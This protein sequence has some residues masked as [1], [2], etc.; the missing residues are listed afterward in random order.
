MV[1]TL[2]NDRGKLLEDWSITYRLYLSIKKT[3]SLLITGKRQGS[4]LSTEDL[5]L[6]IKTGNNNKLEQT[7]S[8]KLLVVHLDQDLNFDEHVDSV[9]NKLFQSIGLLQSIKNFLPKQ[10]GIILCNSLIKPVL[11]Y[12]S[13]VWTTSSNENIRRVFRLHERAAR[14]ILNAGLR[15]E[16]TVTLFNKLNRNPFCHH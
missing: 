7:S 5:T 15:E 13:V 3:K 10:E 1:G 2:R 4:K 6:D 9:C 16:R 8:H 12:G 11:M 14:V